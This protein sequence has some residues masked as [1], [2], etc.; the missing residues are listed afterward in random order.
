M[1]P[2]GQDDGDSQ[3]RA[4]EGAPGPGGEGG[5]Q[6]TDLQKMGSL[7]AAVVAP[8]TFVTAVL[9]YFG[10]AYSEAYFSHF[11]LDPGT[12][13]LPAS[14]LIRESVYPLF[15]PAAVLLLAGLLLLLAHSA[16][17]AVL[18]SQPRRRAPATAGAGV[19]GALGVVLVVASVAVDLSG[20][21]EAWKAVMLGMGALLIVYAY[22]NLMALRTGGLAGIE[23][24]VSLTV[25]VG[26]V[27]LSTFWA[28]DLRASNRG[29]VAATIVA[30]N[31]DLLPAVVVDTRQPLHIRCASISET[32]AD[33][34]PEQGFP[35]SY[36]GLRQLTQVGD[37]VFL[38]PDGWSTEA[39]AV[40]LVRDDGSVRLQYRPAFTDHPDPVRPC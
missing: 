29:R 2:Q 32:V 19:F 28:A 26:L 38:I 16:L 33:P 40:V 5:S 13:Q 18:W 24:V 23:G 3:A 34:L 27:G 30:D 10:Y 21:A 7:L 15:D 6:R 1:A 39:G 36:T 22:R 12:L 37:R 11:G 20:D 17:D 8:T 25:A 31:M 4:T 9:Y 35:F 14:T